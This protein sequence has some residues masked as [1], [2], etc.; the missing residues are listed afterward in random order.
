MRLAHQKDCQLPEISLFSYAKLAFNPIAGLGSSCFVCSP[1]SAQQSSIMSNDWNIE[2][3]M[4]RK[5]KKVSVS[6]G[7]S[8]GLYFVMHTENEIN[9]SKWKITKLLAFEK[10]ESKSKSSTCKL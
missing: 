10:K 6:E 5:N 3:H 8:P 1:D 4:T 2:L 9:F 7:N